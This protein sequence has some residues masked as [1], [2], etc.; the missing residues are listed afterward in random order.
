M[1][2]TALA[3]SPDA[4]QSECGF[5]VLSRF[6]FLSSKMRA[7]ECSAASAVHATDAAVTQLARYLAAAAAE[8]GAVNPFKPSGVK[9]LPYKV[10]KAILV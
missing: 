7:Q 3:A 2:A 6:R 8:A 4:D 10:F 1:P 9:W 5:P